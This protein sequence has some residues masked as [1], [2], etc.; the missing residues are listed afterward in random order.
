MSGAT[1]EITAFWAPAMAPPVGD[2]RERRDAG[3]ADVVVAQVERSEARV[4]CGRA[5][6]RG[7]V[8]RGGWFGSGR[9]CL[10]RFG[11]IWFGSFRFCL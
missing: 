11:L 7:A 5:R 10:V 4:A 2:Q 6:E 9:V 8:R 3:V 1:V